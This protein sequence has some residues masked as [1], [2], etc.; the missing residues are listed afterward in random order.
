MQI[1]WVFFKDD[2]WLLSAWLFRVLLLPG[3]QTAQ[4]CPF[5]MKED[6]K[7]KTSHSKDSHIDGNVIEETVQESAEL[8]FPFS[9]RTKSHIH[10]TTQNAAFPLQVT[11]R[12]TCT[13]YF[14]LALLLPSYL[15]VT[16]ELRPP[17][18]SQHLE[19]SSQELCYGP[20]KPLFTCTVHLLLN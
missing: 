9:N 12:L 19:N 15:I 2:W 10:S 16:A 18:L 4:T 6:K 14:C 11:A 20:E 8:D 17:S 1:T 3:T 7:R 13:R 5:Q